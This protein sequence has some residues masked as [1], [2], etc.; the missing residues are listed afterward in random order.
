LAKVLISDDDPGVCWALRKALEDSGH[1]VQVAGSA[2]L[3][4]PMVDAAE[5]VFLDIGL[6]GMDG[7]TALEQ[8][9]GKPVVVI[10]A[11]G[12]LDNAV[13]AMK[14]G[15]FDYLVK[16]LRSGEIPAL[17][18]RAVRRTELELEV[19]RLRRE[20][21]STARLVGTSD[22]MQQIFKQI[23]T[24]ALSRSPVLL[25]G[26]AGTG[27]ELTARAIHDA[28]NL[29]S[30][31]F[32][33][34]E[35]RYLPE[36]LPDDGTLFVG[37]IDELT[38]EAQARLA[39]VAET[40]APRVIAATGSELASELHFELAA[41]EIHMPPLR[42][43][44]ADIP[45]LV[46]HFLERVFSFPAGIEAAAMRILEAHTWPGN[47]AELRNAV[48]AATVTARGQSI[49]PEHLPNAVRGE[50]NVEDDEVSA[51]VTRLLRTLPDGRVHEL[52][53]E[54]FERALLR[55]VLQETGGNQVQSA[56]RLG[57]HR[58][59]LRKLMDRYGISS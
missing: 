58:T 18:E 10:T 39:R 20:L 43:R 31:P 38:A 8:I 7:F 26:E 28:S 22:S 51:V 35:G 12:T 40:G 52:V 6:P 24:A 13:D 47:V 57:I 15:A 56:K 23:A 44:R 2:E 30:E 3:G 21:G 37:R 36:E 27:R 34:I 54:S 5:L 16:P 33:L 48:E 49:R 25:T 55:Q 29:R 41:S 42:D 14:K 53:Q 4:L 59:T 11:H 46:A 32:H 17:V 45:L 19:T 9:E 1:K 50:E